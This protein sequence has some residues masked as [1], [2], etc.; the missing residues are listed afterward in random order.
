MSVGLL[1]TCM[2]VGVELLVAWWQNLVGAFFF[3]LSRVVPN[4]YI[5]VCCA[6]AGTI[7]PITCNE[8]VR[9]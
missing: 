6:L 2:Y 4:E 5:V 1:F 8:E 7:S 9:A 3:F